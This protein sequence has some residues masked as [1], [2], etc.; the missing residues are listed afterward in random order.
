M[1][2]TTRLSWKVEGMDCAS[3]VA[4]VTTAVERL[5]GVSA[6]EVNLV[7]ADRVVRAFERVLQPGSVAVCFASMAAHMMPADPD[8]DAIIDDVHVVHVD[9]ARG[10]RHQ[11]R[12]FVELAQH[13]IV[14]RL[15]VIDAAAGKRPGPGGISDRRDAGQQHPITVE[16]DRVGT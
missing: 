2:G 12:L 5:P 13:R 4:K 15:P 11:A 3:C 6:V 1:N 8:I 16:G 10:S 7:G 14:R 9:Q